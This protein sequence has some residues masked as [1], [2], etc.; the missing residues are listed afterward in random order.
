MGF[1]QGWMA[2]HQMLAAKPSG[3]IDTH[4]LPGSQSDY[5]F[6]REHMYLPSA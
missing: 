2:L 4:E 1:E 6:S 5:P 3:Q